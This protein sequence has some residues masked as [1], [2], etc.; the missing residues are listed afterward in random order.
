[1]NKYKSHRTLEIVCYSVKIPCFI[2]YICL[3]MLA[4]VKERELSDIKIS[5]HFFKLVL[6]ASLLRPHFNT[7]S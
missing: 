1:M 2:Y 3:C 5:A 7:T 6:H 4:I